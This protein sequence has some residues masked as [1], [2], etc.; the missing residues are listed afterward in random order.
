MKITQETISKF[1]KHVRIR[2]ENEC[3]IYEG[4]HRRYAGF[5]DGRGNNM[6]AH[7]FSMTL[8]VGEIPGG[9][10]VCHTCDNPSC[11]NPN[12]LFLGTPADNSRDMKRKSR[13][14]HLRGEMHSRHKL[15]TEQVRQIRAWRAENRPLKEIAEKFGISFQHVSAIA[16]GEKWK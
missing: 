12:H 5:S 15:T 14:A 9:M 10:F 11:V 3:W 16:R 2:G 1:W 4:K 6:G 8:K 13:Q 7:R